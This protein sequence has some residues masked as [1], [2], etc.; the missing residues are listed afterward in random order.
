MAQQRKSVC[1]DEVIFESC[2][3]ARAPPKMRRNNRDQKI[4]SDRTTGIVRPLLKRLSQWWPR[5]GARTKRL[6]GRRSSWVHAPQATRKD[7]RRRPLLRLMYRPCLQLE[8]RSH[9]GYCRVRAEARVRWPSLLLPILLPLALLSVV[10]FC[11][12]V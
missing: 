9:T 12:L 8:V 4:G 5:E 6:L 3:R 7:P 2:I 10:G 1:D 11:V